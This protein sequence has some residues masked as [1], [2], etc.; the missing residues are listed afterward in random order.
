MTW[1]VRGWRPDGLERLLADEARASVRDARDAADRD[2]RRA[3]RAAER[4]AADAAARREAL[5][6]TGCERREAVR[7]ARPSARPPDHAL[8]S[9]DRSPGAPPLVAVP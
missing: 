4:T 8:A 1:V 9:A 2:A 6:R 3:R 5:E 7:R